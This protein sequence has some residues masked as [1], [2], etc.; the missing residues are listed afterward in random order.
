[1]KRVLNRFLLAV[2]GGWLLLQFTA[3]IILI[4]RLNHNDFRPLPRIVKFAQKANP[5]SWI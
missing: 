5:C 4:H 3:G 2:W 1:M